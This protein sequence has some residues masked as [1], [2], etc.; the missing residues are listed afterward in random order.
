[1]NLL[2][3]K[4]NEINNLKR[5]IDNFEIKINEIEDKYQNIINT[6]EHQQSIKIND[7][8]NNMADEKNQLKYD[9]NEIKKK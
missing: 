2:K 9:F 6:I 3:D 4:E 8:F 1:M 7:L 5:Q